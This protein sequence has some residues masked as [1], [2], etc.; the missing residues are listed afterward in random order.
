MWQKS[1]YYVLLHWTPPGCGYQTLYGRMLVH[2][3][4]YGRSMM[5]QNYWYTNKVIKPDNNVEA[6]CSD[7]E[8]FC[9]APKAVCCCH[10][11]D[12]QCV[13][14]FKRYSGHFKRML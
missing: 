9:K 13:G 4:L 5:G 2:V 10:M 8:D 3:Y 11:T 7:L 1:A 6:N 14:K 12:S